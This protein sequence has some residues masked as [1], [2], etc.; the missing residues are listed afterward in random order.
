MCVVSSAITRL[1][2]SDPDAYRLRAIRW[3]RVC[4]ESPSD[5]TSPSHLHRSR[6]DRLNP[7]LLAATHLP[8]PADTTMAGPHRNLVMHA[9]TESIRS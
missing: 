4:D 3:N 6:M 8:S 1:Q 5:R 7:H 9:S 2:H